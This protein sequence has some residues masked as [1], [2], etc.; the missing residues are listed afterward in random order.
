MKEK[1]EIIQ[2][3]NVPVSVESCIMQSRGETGCYLAC[4]NNGG[5]LNA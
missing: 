4:F 3:I 5:S 2:N 1:L